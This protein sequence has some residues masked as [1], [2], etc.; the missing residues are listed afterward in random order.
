MKYQLIIEVNIR[1]KY[2]IKTILSILKQK[3]KEYNN[4]KEYFRENIFNDYKIKWFYDET[5]YLFNT[6]NEYNYEFVYN[7]TKNLVNYF[8]KYIK[9]I[10]PEFGNKWNFT[11]E[12][13]E[14]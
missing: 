14:K 13:I 4:I 2:F 1:E 7:D 11:F 9:N 12:V 5:L 8:E 10:Y 3:L 6:E